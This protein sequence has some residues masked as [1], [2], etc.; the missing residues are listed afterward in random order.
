MAGDRQTEEPQAAHWK[1]IHSHKL[2]IDP[3][4]R[5]RDDWV[6]KTCARRKVLHVGCA[7]VHMLEDHLETGAFLHEGLQ[8]VCAGLVGV[9]IDEPGIQ[10]LS[11]LGYENLACYDVSTAA[12]DVIA[13][14]RRT[15]GSCDLI[16]CG[17]VLEHVLNAGHFL[18]GIR[19]VATA[20]D[21]EVVITVPNSSSI[22]YVAPLLFGREIVH[23]DH[24]C[25]F[26]QT[27]LKTLLD[28]CGFRTVE[29][30]FCTNYGLSKSRF[31]SLAKR[32]FIGTVLAA[33]PQFA[34][35]LIV[36]ARPAAAAVTAEP[37]GQAVSNVA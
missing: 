22:E 13:M 7:D 10:K 19:K 12:D 32:A 6:L 29:T 16:L 36:V 28:Q 18:G 3:L 35:G 11:D 17:E 14:I 34:E 9:D 8:D 2:R 1:S 26:S 37:I 31:R 23:S 20:F 30:R 25:Y 21:A 5:D 15:M 24:K 33:C 4:I 27:T